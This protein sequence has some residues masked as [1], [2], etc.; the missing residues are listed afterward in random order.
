ME[1]E[2]KE[3]SY[4]VTFHCIGSRN[5]NIHYELYAYSEANYFV[6]F[7][8][9]INYLFLKGCKPWC[10]RLNVKL[11]IL[12]SSRLGALDDMLATA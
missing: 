6:V 12:G 5:G 3:K 9:Y 11:V 1:F 4:G 8:L 7:W 10:K 2:K